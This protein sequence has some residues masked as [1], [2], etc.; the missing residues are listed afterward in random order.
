MTSNN[1]NVV[2]LRECHNLIPDVLYE[3]N[4]PIERVLND[5]IANDMR[6]FVEQRAIRRMQRPEIIITPLRTTVH[7]PDILFTPLHRSHQEPQRQHALPSNGLQNLF[8]VSALNDPDMM[9]QI[10]A[11]LLGE[12]GNP[13]PV[14]PTAEMI[15]AATTVTTTSSAVG[16]CSICRTEYNGTN[17]IRKI[18]H[19]GHEFHLNCIDQWFTEYSTCPNC[20]HDIR[21]RA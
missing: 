2:F 16:E 18:T 17:Q 3:N 8:R 7:P 6:R 20:R 5:I 13:P 11:A 14:P 1:Y 15:A 10:L 19:C 21:T 4:F 12:S 9:G